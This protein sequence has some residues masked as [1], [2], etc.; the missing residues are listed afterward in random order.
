MH[1]RFHCAER[2]A[3]VF[4]NLGIAE[5]L[6]IGQEQYLPQG[7]AE[8]IECFLHHLVPF[9]EIHRG[10]GGGDIHFE[11][12]HKRAAGFGFLDRGREFD[13]LASVLL[14]EVVPCFVRGNCKKPGTKSTR[15]VETGGRDVNL[16]KGVLKNVFC[17]RPI[18][19]HARQEAEEIIVI[20]LDQLPISS[21]FLG[22]EGLEDLLIALFLPI[23]QLVASLMPRGYAQS[24][25][26][27][28]KTG[29]PVVNLG[30]RTQPKLA[31]LP[32]IDR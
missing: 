32:G 13:R 26:R 23:A 19:H 20:P 6:E 14:T 15:T 28:G 30:Y 22:T 17:G 8:L 7:R 3:E 27:F 2:N 21:G 4:G 5:S 9:G 25:M 24:R 10:I 1:P 11:E 18:P 16:E 29:S 31:E 12:I